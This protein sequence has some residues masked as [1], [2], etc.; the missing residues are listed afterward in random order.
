MRLGIEIQDNHVFAAL[1]KRRRER[2]ELIRLFKTTGDFALQEL[3]KDLPWFGVKTIVGIPR[4]NIFLKEIGVDKNLLSHEIEHY[5]EKNISKL[6]GE[7]TKEFYFDFEVSSNPLKSNQIRVIA[8]PKKWLDAF[9]GPL[10]KSGFRLIAADVDELAKAR[11]L[12]VRERLPEPEF[13]TALGLALW[14]PSNEH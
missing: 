13:F 10:K 6:M 3:R 1:I 9:L 11:G 12:A 5:L 4:K 2:W 14:E 8:V 7:L